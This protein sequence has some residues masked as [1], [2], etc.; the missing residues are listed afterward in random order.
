M[1]LDM[2]SC[3][4]VFLHVF[5][6]MGVLEILLYCWATKYY[7]VALWFMGVDIKY[8]SICWNNVFRFSSEEVSGQNQVKASVQRKIRQSITDEV[9][10]TYFFIYDYIMLCIH[11]ALECIVRDRK[12]QDGYGICLVM[13][14]TLYNVT[15]DAVFN[16]ILHS[17]KS[18][19]DTTKSKYISIFLVMDWDS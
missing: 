18:D 14:Y 3:E 17:Y 12:F 9:D 13:N 11:F 1:I 2:F 16:F 8:I 10:Y 4:C 5:N 6:I 19:I 7:F 15:I